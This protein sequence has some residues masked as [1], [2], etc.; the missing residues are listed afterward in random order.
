MGERLTKKLV[1][2]GYQV[3][4]VDYGQ[5][6]KVFEESDLQ[7]KAEYKTEQKFS[8]FIPIFCA[9]KVK[10]PKQNDKEI[11]C[12]IN[13]NLG[14]LRVYLIHTNPGT[15]KMFAVQDKGKPCKE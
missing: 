2:K 12:S 15:E 6:K 14:K 10:L 13:T 7:G 4:K 3:M 8:R 9:S 5:L 1:P 11:Q